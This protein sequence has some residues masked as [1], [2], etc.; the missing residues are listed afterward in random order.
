M[1]Q[2]HTSVVTELLD[3][4]DGWTADDMRGALFAAATKWRLDV[5]NFLFSRMTSP[6]S[7]LARGIT[8]ERGRPQRSGPHNRGDAFAALPKMGQQM[9]FIPLTL[10]Y[11]S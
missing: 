3:L 8:Q 11:Q 2:G 7:G 1:E 6:V 5:I 4:W 10:R 9:P